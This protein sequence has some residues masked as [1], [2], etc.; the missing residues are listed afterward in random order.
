MSEN[1]CSKT[2]QDGQGKQVAPAPVRPVIRP[3]WTREAHYVKPQKP[4]HDETD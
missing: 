4:L 2:S 3:E 1:I